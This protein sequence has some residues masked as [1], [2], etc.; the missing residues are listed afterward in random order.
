MIMQRVLTA[1]NDSLIVLT[2]LKAYSRFE[3]NTENDWL[4]CLFLKKYL[5]CCNIVCF[6]SFT[7]RWHP[8]LFPGLVTLALRRRMNYLEEELIGAFILCRQRNWPVKDVFP[9]LTSYIKE[10]IDTEI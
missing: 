5:I 2:Y 4:S 9:G 3:K 6:W 7:L 1:T 10:A 8:L